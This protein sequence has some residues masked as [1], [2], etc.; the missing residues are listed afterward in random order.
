[1][2]HPGKPL[3]SKMCY[4][5]LQKKITNYEEYGLQLFMVMMILTNMRCTSFSVDYISM[6]KAVK[7]SEASSEEKKQDKEKSEAV[8]DEKAGP[9]KDNTGNVENINAEEFGEGIKNEIPSPTQ[10]ASVEQSDKDKPEKQTRLTKD[11][12]EDIPPSISIV[13][14]EPSIDQEEAKDVKEGSEQ[15]L[16]LKVETDIRQA[17]KIS[18]EVEDQSR[19]VEEVTDS[20]TEEPVTND[21]LDD[22]P[23]SPDIKQYSA[24]DFLLYCTYLPLAFTGPMVTYNDFYE[25]VCIVS[26]LYEDVPYFLTTKN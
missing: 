14:K 5:S 4:P 12:P 1:M 11:S 15:R 20:K 22:V 19:G 17:D 25:Q 7:T 18:N 9:A 6:L 10:N 13:I 24:V 23:R 2:C 26:M 16:Q 21:S 8:Q 3:F